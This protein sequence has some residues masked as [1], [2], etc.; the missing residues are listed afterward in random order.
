MMLSSSAFRSESRISAFI[1][2][3]L[4]VETILLLGK[5]VTPMLAGSKT[6]LELIRI[7]VSTV[8]Q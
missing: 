5:M 8:E 6:E 4:R 7:M 3:C 2:L 1:T